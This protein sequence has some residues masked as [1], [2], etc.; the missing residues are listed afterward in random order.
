MELYTWGAKHVAAWCYHWQPAS[1]P[2]G[3]APR[4]RRCGVSSG[5]GTAVFSAVA[6]TGGII[7]IYYLGLPAVGQNMYFNQSVL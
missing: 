4:Q 5:Q 1:G 3:T 2:R 6:D 7:Y